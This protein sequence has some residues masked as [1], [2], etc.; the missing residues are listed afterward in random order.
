MVEISH[1][2]ENQHNLTWEEKGISMYQAMNITRPPT[3]VEYFLGIRMEMVDPVVRDAVAIFAQKGY[4]PYDSCQGHDDVDSV[5][6]GFHRSFSQT[7]RQYFKS[8][9]DEGIKIVND[10]V[11]Y[12]SK[13]KVKRTPDEMREYLA[14]VAR[15]APKVGEMVFLD[16]GCHNYFFINE[17]GLRRNFPDL[18]HTD[19]LPPDRFYPPRQ[20]GIQSKINFLNKLINRS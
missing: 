7:D 4:I 5:H 9:A 14:G 15:N 17:I 10:R 20:T 3:E 16:Q 18:F 11:I 12:I 6:I 2:T 13:F 8:L 19:S 1:I